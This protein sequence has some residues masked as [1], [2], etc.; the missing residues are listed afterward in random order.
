M[1]TSYTK[2]SIDDKFSLF[3]VLMSVRKQ[4][5]R[6]LYFVIH[7]ACPIDFIKSRTYK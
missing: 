6:S 4:I 2:K 3:L 5:P 7:Y 1:D